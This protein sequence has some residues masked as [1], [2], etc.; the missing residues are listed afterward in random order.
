MWEFTRT[1]VWFRQ[2]GIHVK[3]VAER[4]IRACRQ[5]PVGSDQLHQ[6]TV[7]VMDVAAETYPRHCWRYSV[8]NYAPKER[9]T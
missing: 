8:S 1:G 2:L 6:T 4:A 9:H 7:V 3:G 5:W